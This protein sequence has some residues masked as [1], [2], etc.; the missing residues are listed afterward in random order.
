M[1]RSLL[2]WPFSWRGRPLGPVWPE[3][4]T[5]REPLRPR[6]ALE[7]WEQEDEAFDGRTVLEDLELC[8]GDAAE[9]TLVLA[10]YVTVR[11]VLG[12]L[13]G[14]LRGAGLRAEREAALEYV[15]AVAPR[16]GERR[17]LA[18]LVAGVRRAAPRVVCGV[19]IGAG[20]EAARL[21]HVA[22]AFA[23]CRAAY[24][25]AL[26]AGWSA[27]GARAATALAALAEAGGGRWSAKRWRRRARV[28]AR[29]AAREEG[30]LGA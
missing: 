28:L 21:S 5:G 6:R 2:E 13:L 8:A 18:A 11:L 24:T 26:R 27:E 29:R 12:A 30:R 14:E 25:V 9:S 16:F 22:S 20:R 10:R 23:L 17:W 3:S 19:L 7:P 4:G 15:A 1:R